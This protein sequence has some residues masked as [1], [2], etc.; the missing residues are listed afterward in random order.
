MAD[1]NKP[2]QI[3]TSKQTAPKGQAVH[4]TAGSGHAKH[5]LKG[6][7]KANPAGQGNEGDDVMMAGRETS[8]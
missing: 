7:P 2:Q 3:D 1:K 8:G 6:N 5:K 4:P